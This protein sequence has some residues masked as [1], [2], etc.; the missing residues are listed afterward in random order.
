MKRFTDTE[1]EQKM[2]PENKKKSRHIN[3]DIALEDVGGFG[4]FQMT[5]TVAV[6]F[7]RTAGLWAYYCFSYLTLQQRYLC[8]TQAGFVT[9]VEDAFDLFVFGPS[10]DNF[11]QDVQWTDW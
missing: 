6:M 3:V 7:W 5:M 11:S 9:E 2:P 4:R 10:E 8:R 1:D